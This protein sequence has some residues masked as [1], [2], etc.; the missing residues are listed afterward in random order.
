MERIA[1]W[2]DE[3]IAHVDDE[4][5]IARVCDEV[6]EFCRGFPAPGLRYSSG[7]RPRTAWLNCDA[8]YGLHGARQN[9]R[10]I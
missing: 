6:R 9:P 3:V 5:T 4:A 8:D 10:P 2:I 7:G 1:V